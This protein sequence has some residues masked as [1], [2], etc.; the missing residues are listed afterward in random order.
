MPIFLL[1]NNEHTKPR[2]NIT[3]LKGAVECLIWT[4]EWH[5][6]FWQKSFTGTSMA[7]SCL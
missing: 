4:A 1:P 2:T 5:Q 6:Q 3:L 7:C